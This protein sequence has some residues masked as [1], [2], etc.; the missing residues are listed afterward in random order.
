MIFTFVT[1]PKPEVEPL[2]LAAAALLCSL[3]FTCG[4]R[5]SVHRKSC[6]YASVQRYVC[7][8]ADVSTCLY[9]VQFECI[10]RQALCEATVRSLRV[11]RMR[12][13]MCLDERRRAVF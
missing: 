3:V 5:S 10:R 2:L 11:V 7:T 9:V 4:E 12:M 1:R 6:I 13:P 8:Y